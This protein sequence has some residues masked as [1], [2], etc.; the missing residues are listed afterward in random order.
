MSKEPEMESCPKCGGN[1]IISYP[2]DTSIKVSCE[3][4][5]CFGFVQVCVDI[6]D[7]SA[8]DRVRKQWNDFVDSERIR[9]QSAKRDAGNEQIEEIAGILLRMNN[10]E[11]YPEIDCIRDCCRCFAI[12]IYNA[13][14]HKTAHASW[15]T[16]PETEDGVIMRYNHQCT[17]CNY[18]YKTVCPRGDDYCHK[19]GAKMKGV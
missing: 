19:C 3:A 2:N 4:N 7:A 10:C 8:I 12:Q 13:G 17:G 5:N 6:Y 1:A 11:K 15:I 16:T 9:M 18:F 14:F